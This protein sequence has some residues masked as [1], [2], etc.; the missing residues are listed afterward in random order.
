MAILH[1]LRSRP[2][3]QVL[4]LIRS[5][6]PGDSRRIALYDEVVDYDRLVFE[7]FRHDRV[8]AWW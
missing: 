5:T 8:S 4:E 3:D 2:D 7:I 6:E 1:V